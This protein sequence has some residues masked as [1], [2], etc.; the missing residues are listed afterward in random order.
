MSHSHTPLNIGKKDYFFLFRNMVVNIFTFIGVWTEGQ[1]PEKP[2]KW[3]VFMNRKK[4]LE[5]I[6]SDRRYF[7]RCIR[8]LKE[9]D[10]PLEGWEC[11]DVI[12]MREEDSSADL[13]TCELCGCS[14]VRNVHIMEH[15]EY[16]EPVWVG[17]I[18]AGFMEGDIYKAADRERLMRNRAK[19]RKNF[20]K[21]EWKHDWP[22]VWERIYQKKELEIRETAGLFT[23]FADGK[24]T[25]TYKGK[26][27]MDLYSAV[28]AAFELADPKE[29][30]ICGKKI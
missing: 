1:K 12:D 10:A 14:C 26:P 21:H 22:D 28:Y 24:M 27:I 13:F 30:I 2:M 23:V 9:W 3:E 16:F 19:R 6:I 18:C 8:R 11:T 5:R 4:R 15:E 25:S 29:D 20:L 7:A 17:C